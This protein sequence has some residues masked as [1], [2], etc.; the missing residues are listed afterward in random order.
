MAADEDIHSDPPG[1][2]MVN[3]ASGDLACHAIFNFEKLSLLIWS[4]G[5]YFVLA[6]SPPYVGHSPAE[7]DGE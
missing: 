4:S 1:I 7:V 6:R 2:V 3:E 5:E